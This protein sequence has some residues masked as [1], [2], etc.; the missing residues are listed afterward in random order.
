M[1]RYPPIARSTGTGF[2]EFDAY[3]FDKID[4]RNLRFE[5]SRKRGWYKSGTRELLFDET[6]PD[7][8]RALPLFRQQLATPLENIARCER[9]DHLIAFVECWT[10][11]S[12]SGILRTDEEMRLTVFDLARPDRDE[13]VG[14]REFLALMGKA[15]IGYVPRFLGQHRWTRGFVQRVW[16]G[17]VDGVTFEGVVGKSTD[18]YMAKAKTQAWVNTILREHGEARG[19]QIVES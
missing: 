8:G 12:L 1:F 7:V 15:E 16:Q 10:L 13:M 14:P 11:H 5:W 9:W 3:V 19:R 2:R 18:G 6:D 4:G 17:D